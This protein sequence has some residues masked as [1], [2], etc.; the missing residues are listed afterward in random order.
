VS[1]TLTIPSM[2]DDDN[3]PAIIIGIP[4]TVGDSVTKGD[5]L[6]EIE[7]DKATI[8]I[9]AEKA[10][11]IEALFLDLGDKAYAGQ[12]FATL[13]EAADLTGDSAES[14]SEQIVEISP[15]VT[16]PATPVSSEVTT[17][18]EQSRDAP[19]PSRGV[20]PSGPSARRLARE[21]GV[22]IGEVIGSGSG[23][24]I[25]KADVKS[26]AKRLI[27]QQTGS[28]P[29]SRSELRPL[30]D[31][32]EF[33]PIH[34][35]SISRFSSASALNLTHTWSRVPHAWLQE[36]VDI[37]ELEDWRDVHKSRVTE[38]GGSLTLTV[39]IAKAVGNALKAFPRLN[40]AL[41][42]SSNELVLR[43]YEDVGV[44]VDTSHG[45]VVPTLR[46]VNERGLTEL[47]RDLLLLTDKA[48]DQKLS[49]KD[50]QGGGITITNLGGTGLD[51]IFPIINWPQTA[52][53]GVAAG[54]E[55]PVCRNGSITPRK[56]MNITLGFDHRVINGA[57]GARF[58]VYVRDRLEDIRLTLL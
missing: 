2:G 8:E 3:A 17:G 50:L 40:S 49:P 58:L 41:D 16:Q 42:E 19:L 26:Y 6:L 32:S 53:L 56:M 48:R 55:I 27:T 34:R 7:T 33:G 22:D 14:E 45:L 10:G 44:A 30:P 13:R 4:I 47:A 25:S 11:R 1:E 38:N 35:E 12:P 5:T 21:V 54:R 39:I 43:E 57:E 52:I 46:S 20:A 9:P 28:N 36:S 23:A 31:L 29:T 51:A 24:R 37:T 15:N 18:V